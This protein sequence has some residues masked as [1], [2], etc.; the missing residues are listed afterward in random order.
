MIFSAGELNLRAFFE[1]ARFGGASWCSLL[2]V[3]ELVRTTE[4]DFSSGRRSATS[5]PRGRLR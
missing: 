5:C 3:L 1:N 4:I 2:S